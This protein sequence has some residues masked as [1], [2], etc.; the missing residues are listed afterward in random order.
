MNTSCS[1]LIRSSEI[2]RGQPG[3]FSVFRHCKA[4]S[5]RARVGNQTLTHYEYEFDVHTLKT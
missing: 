3:S 1:V 2:L 4:E 5:L